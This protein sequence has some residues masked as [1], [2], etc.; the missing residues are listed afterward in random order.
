VSEE[1]QR[2]NKTVIIIAVCIA[3][4]WLLRKADVFPSF[5]DLFEIEPV[6]IDNTPI[7]VKK[8][9]SIGQVITATLYDE[10]VVD[11]LERTTASEIIRTINKV[12]P[13]PILP[14]ADKQLVLIARGKVLA[15]TDLNALV[16]SSVRA[17]K[18]TVWLHL[19]SAKI[20]DVIMNPSDV[21]TF[22]E[23]GV[24]SAKA[25]AAVKEKARSKMV[26][27]AQERHILYKAGNKT[28]TV[29]EDFLHAAGFKVV[30]FVE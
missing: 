10:V 23:R 24:W 19:P 21:E 29:L 30:L 13:F 5:R 27:H 25:V 14:P 28:K 4:L 8:I 16:D 6:V 26:E 18:D 20:I 12:T 11:S 17:A 15:G 9:K 7:L 22:E 2:W 1:R 3:G